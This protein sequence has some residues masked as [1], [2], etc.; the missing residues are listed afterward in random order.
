LSALAAA[1]A[2]AVVIDFQ[3][4]T[5]NNSFTYNTNVVGSTYTKNG[6]T[7]NA[8]NSSSFG[9]EFAGTQAPNYAGST[10]LFV[11]AG[12]GSSLLTQVGGG[13]FNLSSIDL[14]ANS[15]ITAT[16]TGTKADNS[17]VTR[18][19][20]TDTIQNTFQTV[21]FTNFTDLVR[22]DWSQSASYIQFDNINVSAANSTSVPE[23]F[24]V[25]GTIFGAGYG[26]AMKRK[27][28]KAQADKQDIS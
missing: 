9:L 7:I 27:L 14:T 24:T 8:L 16:F 22:V 25:L 1:P 6:F 23:P 20:A 26:V 28:A 5:L 4:L 11:W 2:K 17:T 15:T 21:N 18:S 19:F 10:A 3:E 12:G 13:T